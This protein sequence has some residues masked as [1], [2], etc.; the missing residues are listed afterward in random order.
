MNSSPQF[1]SHPRPGLAGSGS[2]TCAD[3]GTPRLAGTATPVAGG[4]DISA[5]GADIWEKSD[6]FHFVCQDVAGDFDVAVRVESFTPAHLYSK[7]G[8]MIRESLAADS[9]HLMLVLF[10]DNQPRNNNLGA[11]EMQFRATAGEDCQAVYPAVRPP[12]PPEFP[13]AFPHCWLRVTRRGNRFAALASTDGRNW[14]RYAEQS[15]ALAAALKVGPALTSHNPE[16]MAQA[17]FRD[18][19][20]AI[21]HAK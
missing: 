21:G 16:M 5:G 11:Y 4:W 14:N 17:A 1:G 7:A 19:T 20:L 3:V 10:A 15:L 6:Q 9:A 2:F 18:H 8:L 13:A 12:A